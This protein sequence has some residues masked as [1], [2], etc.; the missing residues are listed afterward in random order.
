MQVDRSLH[1]CLLG[2]TG[3]GQSTFLQCLRND[4]A[5]AD[6]KLERFVTLAEFDGQPF[7]VRFTDTAG[8][9]CFKSMWSPVLGTAHAV[10]LCYAV[11]RSASL[12]AL[13]DKWLP[14]FWSTKSEAPVFVVGLRADMRAQENEPAQCV[15][16]EMGGEFAGRVGAVG[17]FECSV[18]E[19]DSVQST[20]DQILHVAKEYYSLQWQLGPRAAVDALPPDDSAPHAPWL[21]HERLNVC[22]DPKVLDTATIRKNLS[23]LGATPACQHAYLRIDVPDLGLTSLDAIREFK[24]LQFVN[25]SGN[26]L[27]TLEPLGALRCLLHLNASF[28]LIIRTQGFTAPDQLETVD[29]SY[30]MISDLGEWGVHKYL[31]ELNLRGNFISHIGRGLKKNAELRMLDISENYISQIDSMD[32]LGLHTLYLA[33]N[34][35]TSLEGIGHLTKLQVLNVRHNCI[36]SISALRSEDIPRLR[37]LCI[38][39]NRISHIQEI[40]GLQPF[41]YL[42]DLLLSPNPLINLPY[43]REQVLHRLPHL[44]LLDKMPATPEEKVKSDIIYGS[45]I[46]M[47]RQIFEDQLPQETFIDR[48][49]VTEEGIGDDELSKFQQQGCAWEFGGSVDSQD[50]DPVASQTSFGKAQSRTHFQEAAFRKCL[51]IARRGGDPPGVA[52]FQN[53]SAPFMK[54]KVYD[55]DIAELL[56]VCFEGG[57]D[58]IRLGGGAACIGSSAL[59]QLLKALREG[60]LFHIDLSGCESVQNVLG[61]LLKGVPF[62]RGCSIE[63][64]NCGIPESEVVRLRNLTPEAETARSRAEQIR[65]LTSVL[66][67]RQSDNREALENFALENRVQDNP[68][69]VITPL[70]HPMQWREGI[71]ARAVATH[72]AFVKMNPNGMQED[73]TQRSFSFIDPSGAKITLSK[74]EY[75]TLDMQRRSLLTEGSPLPV[76]FENAFAPVNESQAY[77]AFMMWN[78]AQAVKD[79]IEQQMRQEGE[80]ERTWRENAERMKALTNLSATHYDSAERPPNI[81][82]AQLIAHFTYL[83][84]SCVLKANHALKPLSAFGLKWLRNDNRP[85]PQSGQDLHALAV[86]G[87]V[88]IEAIKGNG[89][90]TD[91]LELTLRSSTLETLQVAIQK[92]TIFQ[93]VGWEHRQNLLVAND[94]VVSLPAWISVCKKMRTFSMNHT[95]AC[96]CDS[97]LSLTEFYVDDP[98]ILESQGLVWDYFQRRFTTE[99]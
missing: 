39:E 71:E 15:P 79:V 55:S 20:V 57:I 86:A 77:I 60:P 51:E 66:C 75:D 49:L 68:P 50:V 81:A 6:E 32:G 1:V 99:D 73:K 5:N 94:Y 2:E 67:T 92:G 98:G 9:N 63:A 17:Y 95:C 70:Y 12:Q 80:L 56:E 18:F 19:P 47:R 36:T 41:T 54:I 25:L 85:A 26:R 21:T 64:S 87:K 16:E 4:G 3:V 38:S 52:D 69:P 10:L 31:R 42:C 30:N 13:Q 7:Y 46:D 29:M 93:Q 72:N 76:S 27:R 61:E 43:Y 53:L 74:D 35:L 45:D 96:A 91:S 40:E 8:S 89:F 24:H 14:L 62:D 44:R 84:S 88:R 83:A 78:G 33:Q 58:V 97:P 82:S 65:E 22:D 37:K 59:R 28:N 48:R 11:D 23:M 90:G 34:R